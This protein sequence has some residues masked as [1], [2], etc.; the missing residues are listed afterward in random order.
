MSDYLFRGSLEK[1][2]PDV[3]E[4]T[5]LEAGAAS[6]QVDSDCQRIDCADGGARGVIFRVPK[7]LCRRLP[8]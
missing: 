2:D 5:Q 8:R 3:Y 1:L 6:P 4:L 7:Y